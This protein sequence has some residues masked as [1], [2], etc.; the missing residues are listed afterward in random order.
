MRDIR[1]AATKVRYVFDFVN[2]LRL[3]RFSLDVQININ[4][5]GIFIIS[6]SSTVAQNKQRFGFDPLSVQR[7]SHQMYTTSRWI[8]IIRIM[9]GTDSCKPFTLRLH[10]CAFTFSPTAHP[11]SPLL[12]IFSVDL[13]IETGDCKNNSV[14]S[15]STCK[16][17]WPVWVRASVGWWSVCWRRLQLV[18]RFCP[19]FDF[20][21]YIYLLTRQPPHL[22][23]AWSVELF[24]VLVYFV[25]TWKTTQ[26]F[27]FVP[28]YLYTL[29][30]SSWAIA[31]RMRNDLKAM[32]G[33]KNNENASSF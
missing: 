21:T 30:G 31:V 7:L 28:F 19:A 9:C 16:H 10:L 2:L 24:G 5:M 25:Y 22:S 4:R 3:W 12:V 18:W 17:M 1:V 13:R 8:F 32:N 27:S 23:G 33:R 6:I 14:R 11:F 29:I 15:T 26:V 20:D